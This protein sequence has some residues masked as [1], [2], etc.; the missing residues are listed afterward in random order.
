MGRKGFKS[1]IDPCPKSDGELNANASRHED[2]I[3]S[4]T[5]NSLT[6]PKRAGLFPKMPL[7]I[8]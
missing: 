2:A 4:N 3:S 7:M 8:K 1:A 5:N 6:I